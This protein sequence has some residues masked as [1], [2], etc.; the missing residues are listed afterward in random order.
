MCNFFVGGSMVHWRRSKKDVGEIPVFLTYLVMLLV[1]FLGGFV[2]RERW[3]NITKDDKKGGQNDSGNG[4]GRNSDGEH[5]IFAT[6]DDNKEEKNDKKEKDKEQ[7]DSDGDRLILSKDE[8]HFSTKKWSNGLWFTGYSLSE[9]RRSTYNEYDMR[10]F[11]ENLEDFKRY[12]QTKF[13]YEGE[14][15]EEVE[16]VKYVIR[17][18]G[19]ISATPI[20]TRPSPGMQ[21]SL[22]KVEEGKKA[23]DQSFHLAEAKVVNLRKKL[24]HVVLP[25]LESVYIMDL[26]QKPHLKI[27][28]E[29][30][31]QK[32]QEFK[33]F[34]A[35]TVV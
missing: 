28:Q 17:T 35:K 27:L 10:L 26:Q 3:G 32:M 2:L 14:E 22:D 8:Y 33:D 1:G 9:R 6:K 31:A 20:V 19:N 11:A 21:W 24:Y 18:V 29:H 34:V 7:N 4:E 30:L 5:F 16:G 12:S 25:K 13:M 15:G 23:I